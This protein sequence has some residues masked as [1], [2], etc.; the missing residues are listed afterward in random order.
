[1][2]DIQDP[3]SDTKWEFGSFMGQLANMSEAEKNRIL[4]CHVFMDGK[5]DIKAAAHAFGTTSEKSMRNNY[6]TAMKKLKSTPASTQNGHQSS[7][8]S[9]TGSKT[10]AAKNGAGEGEK[11]KRGIKRKTVD[12]D[13]DS[14]D[15]E[16]TKESSKGKA[17]VKKI[18]KGVKAN[19]A[20]KMKASASTNSNGTQQVDGQIIKPEATEE[21]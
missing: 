11:P 3:T 10:A 8:Q 5:I 1:M 21:T 12:S 9:S 2:A 7:H 16:Q 14:E 19:G 17:S 20:G 13:D 4:C 15:G 18:K 6:G